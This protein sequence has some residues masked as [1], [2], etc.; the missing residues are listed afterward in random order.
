MILD[1]IFLD[2][3]R[4]E[5]DFFAF[6]LNT[7]NV[8]ETFLHEIFLRYQER[9]LDF[10]TPPSL[11]SISDGS[12]KYL[13]PDIVLLKNNLPFTIIDA[14]YKFKLDQ[15]D[16]NQIIRY[17]GRYNIN[18]G[19]LIYPYHVG[20][21]EGTKILREIQQEMEI[22]VIVRHIYLSKT[23]DSVYLKEFVKETLDLI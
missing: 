19:F 14:K 21:Q 2:F 15:S 10:S 16:E 11:N 6:V 5:E 20:V 13:R 1:D 9:D 12:T 23:N 8:Y 17:I 22:K 18:T 3:K 4:G 7:W